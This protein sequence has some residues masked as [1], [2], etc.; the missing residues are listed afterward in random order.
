MSD[1]LDELGRQVD[2]AAARQI[3]TGRRRFRLPRPQAPAV[4]L[5]MALLVSVAVVAVV[6]PDNDGRGVKRPAT[7]APQSRDSGAS[8][9]LEAMLSVLR[10]PISESDAIPTRWT[11][12]ARRN[13]IDTSTFAL[14]RKVDTGTGATDWII[15]VGDQVCQMQVAGEAMTYGCFTSEDIARGRALTTS[16][17]S[18]MGVTDN[19]VRVSGVL[20]DGARDPALVLAS[21]DR[22]TVTVQRN[23]YDFVA[24]RSAKRFQWIDARGQQQTHAIQTAF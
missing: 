9:A 24:P 2:A 16:T 3:Q 20:P 10:E 4:G 18:A 17:G 19:E 7:E 5:A 1:F 15:P 23:V 22:Q 14:A 6:V 21:G 12:E 11:T 13:G 8:P